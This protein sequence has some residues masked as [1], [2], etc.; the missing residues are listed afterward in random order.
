MAAGMLAAVAAAIYASHRERGREV[1]EY[2]GR[3]AKRFAVGCGVL[4]GL[5]WWLW[6]WPSILGLGIVLMSL[7]AKLLSKSKPKP[8]A[9][10]ST[11]IATRA[12][13]R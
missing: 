1:F 6:F 8:L 4:A 13:P 3:L 2:L 12:M 11:V 9:S 10:Q 5:V 7:A